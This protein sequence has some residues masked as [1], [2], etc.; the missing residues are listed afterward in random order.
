MCLYFLNNAS[1]GKIL[2]NE[3]IL[4]KVKRE[5]EAL[6]GN[7]IEDA[8]LE[9]FGSG[10]LD[11]LN[12]LHI[13]TY[14]ESEFGISINPFDITLDTLGSLNKICNYVSNKIKK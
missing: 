4:G 8:D 9:I 6:A 5:V 1:G 2:D 7:E 13:I 14:I 3:K 12:V 11:S 10:I